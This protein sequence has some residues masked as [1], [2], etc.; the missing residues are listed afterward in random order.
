M[1]QLFERFL[2]A[3]LSSLTVG[4]PFAG[5][6]A[7]SFVDMAGKQVEF[8][9]SMLR[10]FARNTKRAITAARE[11]GMPG[12]PIDAR[13]H[14][15][16]D[17]A[18]WI[19]DA[20]RGHV[21][22][23]E[24]E[25]VPVIMLQAEWTELGTELISKRLMVNFSPTV[26]LEGRVIRGGSLTNWPA[27]VDASGVPLFPAIELA[28][29]LRS[30]DHRLR[31]V[32]EA[33]REAYPS[34]DD[35]RLP[36]LFASEVFDDHV[37]VVESK[38]GLEPAKCYRVY[39]Q[40]D[41]D[42]RI[43]FDPKE[44]WE[45]VEQTWAT[46]EGEGGVED[47]DDVEEEGELAV[48][49]TA[50]VPDVVEMASATTL[51]IGEDEIQMDKQELEELVASQVRTA[52]VAELGR[53]TPRPPEVP[54]AQAPNFDVLKL[55]NLGEAT[56]DVVGAFKQQ[57]LDQYELMRQR[58][59]QEAAEMIAM[60]RRDADIAEFTQ[61]VT[62]GTSEVPYGLPVNQADLKEFLSRQSPGDYAFAKKLLSDL[63]SQGRVPFAELGHGKQLR[64][65][66][67]LPEPYRS[68]LAGH[69]KLGG[70]LQAW[71]EAAE[72]GDPTEY[73]LSEFEEKK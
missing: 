34:G 10:D 23:S 66:K 43:E 59:S 21:T 56:D 72:L 18:G 4:K 46:V 9:E 2:F 60:I 68:Y 53:S 20:S 26:D 38:A 45:V 37:I 49:E 55:L 47:D 62:H 32:H 11:R 42:G 15:K 17:A 13:Q 61:Q 12:L 31:R 16:G 1:I 58:A 3:E 48:T 29:G 5:F 33:W 22:N 67:D 70:D 41:P 14:D 71:F 73:N 69:L 36:A 7:G 27:S 63:V 65:T 24:N 50:L 40:E 44:Y 28:Q 51:S 39:Y 8:T 57:M 6:A 64:G 35:S 54:N 19:T 25:K 30:L 52:L